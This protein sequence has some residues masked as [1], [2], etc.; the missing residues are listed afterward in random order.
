MVTFGEVYR[1]YFKLEIYRQD[2]TFLYYREKTD[3]SQ[4]E[5]DLYGYFV[6]IMSHQMTAKN[7]LEL[8]K[9]CK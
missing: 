7:A 4:R 5:I 9:G 1:K 3:V 8:Y 2:S 6:I